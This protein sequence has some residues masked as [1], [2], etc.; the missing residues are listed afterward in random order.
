MPQHNG[1]TT[2]AGKAT[3]VVKKYS[4]NQS[5]NGVRENIEVWVDLPIKSDEGDGDAQ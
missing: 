4:D 2:H 1:R 5:E 3:A